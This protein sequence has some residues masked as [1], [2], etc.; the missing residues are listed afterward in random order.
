M[1]KV[2]F[3]VPFVLVLGACDARGPE[4]ETT[5]DSTAVIVDTTATLDTVTVQ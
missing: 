4:A 5:A 1:N 3:V 2:L